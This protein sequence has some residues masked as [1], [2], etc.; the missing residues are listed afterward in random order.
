MRHEILFSMGQQHML[1]GK[2]IS[3]RISYPCH[4]S[5]PSSNQQQMTHFE[6]GLDTRSSLQDQSN[7]NFSSQTSETGLTSIHSRRETFQT[8]RHMHHCGCTSEQKKPKA[9]GQE[10][11][12]IQ[13][14]SAQTE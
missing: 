6:K 13:S 12:V 14:T 9:F 7:C 8:K 10:L 2:N 3:I 1:S 4:T 5:S 11:F